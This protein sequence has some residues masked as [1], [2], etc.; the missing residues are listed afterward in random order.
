MKRRFLC[1]I[2]L[3]GVSACHN[4]PDYY[5]GPSI[6]GLKFKAGAAISGTAQDT[7]IVNVIAQNQS[8]KATIIEFPNCSRLNAVSAEVRSKEHIWSSRVWEIQREQRIRDSLRSPVTEVCALSLLV[9]SFPPG[10]AYTFALRV[11]IREILYDSLSDGRYRV[12]ASLA[13][14][15]RRIDHLFAGEIEI[16]HGTPPNTR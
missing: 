4:R 8:K 9:M 1:A 12:S 3:L 14:N 11:P 10:G 5:V 15:G 2:A 6:K 16:G 13:I 7:L